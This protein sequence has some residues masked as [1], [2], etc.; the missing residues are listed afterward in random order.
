MGWSWVGEVSFRIWTNLL[1]IR[2]ILVFAFVLGLP[3]S[4]PQ[5]PFCPNLPFRTLTPHAR[6]AFTARPLLRVGL[7][8]SKSSPFRTPSFLHRRRAGLSPAEL[9]SYISSHFFPL[10]CPRRYSLRISTVI[11]AAGY[12]NPG[13]VRRKVGNSRAPPSPRL[14]VC[15]TLRVRLLDDKSSQCAVISLSLGQLVLFLR[16]LRL[17]SLRILS[18]ARSNRRKSVVRSFGYASPIS[19]LV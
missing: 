17:L 18:L 2:M 10:R 6:H 3:F 19:F 4:I 7:P 15:F 1:F 13:P 5:I 14:F 16:E 9:P 12:K 11:D 8:F